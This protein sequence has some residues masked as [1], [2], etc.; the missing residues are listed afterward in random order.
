VV[1][2][3]DLPYE[4]G[5]GFHSAATGM[6][7]DA[8]GGA[9]RLRVLSAAGLRDGAAYDLRRRAPRAL[10]RRGHPARGLLRVRRHTSARAARRH[11]MVVEDLGSTNGTYLKRRAADR[12][13]PPLH[14][15]DRIR[16]GDSEFAFER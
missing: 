3:E 6:R 4:E 5:T 10:G 9:P 7:P 1:A 16:I 12:A 2:D 15:G 13:Q 11:V 8:D 14:P